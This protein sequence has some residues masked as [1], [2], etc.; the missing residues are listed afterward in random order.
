MPH[1]AEPASPTTD[2]WPDVWRRNIAAIQADLDAIEA[3]LDRTPTMLG[4]MVV[5]V[6]HMTFISVVLGPFD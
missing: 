6:A 5:A 2:P 4:W 1:R 3:R